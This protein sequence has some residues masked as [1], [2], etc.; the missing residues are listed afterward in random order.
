M[1]SLYL[2]EPT[3]TS[4][5]RQVVALP[6]LPLTQLDSAVDELR[7]FDFNKSSASYDKIVSFKEQ[8]LNYFEQTWIQ[9]SFA[10]SMWNS[11]MRGNNLTNNRNE[12]RM[13]IIMDRNLVSK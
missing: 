8:L 11:W 12:G 1:A 7:D 13:N 4:F 9:G 6:F 10:P 3:F 2:S 5:V